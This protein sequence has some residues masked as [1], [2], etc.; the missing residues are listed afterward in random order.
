MK[1]YKLF[2]V[3][4]SM[5]MNKIEKLIKSLGY[6][7]Y[8]SSNKEIC[9]SSANISLIN[10][11]YLSAF[12][13]KI[14]KDLY[15]SDRYETI[16]SWTKG[17]E[18]KTNKPIKLIEKFAKT[19]RQRGLRARQHGPLAPKKF[20]YVARQIRLFVELFALEQIFGKVICKV[21]R[22]RVTL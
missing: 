7:V 5:I 9:F 10:D 16:L 4:F 21:G 22:E 11:E 17:D 19:L 15:L 18:I 6:D 2:Y 13:I 8:L 14:N 1:K 3:G 12:I 20:A